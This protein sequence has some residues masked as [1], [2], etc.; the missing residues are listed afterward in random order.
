RAIQQSYTHPSQGGRDS[1]ARI[2]RDPVAHAAALR[3]QLDR[4]KQAYQEQE[5]FSQADH[6]LGDH[7]LLLNIESEPGFELQVQSLERV[8]SGIL[9]LNVRR[10]KNPDGVRF[11]EAAVFVPYGKLHILENQVAAYE[12][13]PPPDRSRKNEKLLV[14]IHRIR[15]AALE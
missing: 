13:T 5:W 14:N 7:G 12:R 2:Q 10:R 11:V 1:F 4:A 8:A 15:L 3:R 6:Q 9:L